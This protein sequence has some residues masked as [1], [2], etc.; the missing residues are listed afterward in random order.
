MSDESV[1]TEVPAETITEPQ[2][3]K[4]DTEYGYAEKEVFSGEKTAGFEFWFPQFETS[5]QGLSK[6]QDFLTKNSATGK[7]GATTVVALINSAIKG[8]VRNLA[9]SRLMVNGK[10]M[11]EG[12]L[13]EKLEKNPCLYT[14][15]EANEYSPGEREIESVSGLERQLSKLKNNILK[16]KEEN[17]TD[18]VLSLIKNWKETKAQLDTLVAAKEQEKLAFINQFEG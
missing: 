10:L 15:E 9:N 16:A 8:R 1:K 6:L 13:A 11:E 5:A 17:K 3:V 7:D 12:K 4:V 2:A 14:L 18:L